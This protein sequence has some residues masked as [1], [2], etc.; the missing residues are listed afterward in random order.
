MIFSPEIETGFKTTDRT[1]LIRK[2]L[3]KLILFALWIFNPESLYNLGESLS[4][5]F[6]KFL[7][8]SLWNVQEAGRLNINEHTADHTKQ[9]NTL[10]LRHFSPPNAFR[11]EIFG[12]SVDYLMHPQAAASFQM[13]LN[14][15]LVR[16]AVMK[17][18]F[19]LGS[20]CSGTGQGGCCQHQW[21]DVRHAGVSSFRRPRSWFPSLLSFGVFALPFCLISSLSFSLFGPGVG[22]RTSRLRCIVG[23]GLQAAWTWTVW[24]TLFSLE[25]LRINH[26]PWQPWPQNGGG[27]LVSA[28]NKSS[29]C[30]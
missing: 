24:V 19:W 5:A 7:T 27:L 4:K 2:P 28:S 23:S 13:M 3:I 12:S 26:T 16:V 11:N 14:S 1:S 29:C 20:G 15:T 8:S 17:S 6:L 21:R 30:D 9:K 25:R 22:A 18:R 10:K